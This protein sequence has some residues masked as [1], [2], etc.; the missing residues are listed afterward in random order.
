MFTEAQK[1]T[2]SI[3]RI[4]RNERWEVV[5]DFSALTLVHSFKGHEV[6]LRFP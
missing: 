5:T 2:P 3:I 4:L 6:Q 1:L